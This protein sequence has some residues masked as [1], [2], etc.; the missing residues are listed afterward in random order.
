MDYNVVISQ[1]PFYSHAKYAKY[2]MAVRFKKMYPCKKKYI[3][4]PYAANR[5][6]YTGL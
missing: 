2:V 3:L 6:L 5:Y 4:L 1:D